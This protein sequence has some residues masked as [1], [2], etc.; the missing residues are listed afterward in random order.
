M[1]A[2]RVNPDIYTALFNAMASA[3][4]DTI[5]ESVSAL[6]TDS[7]NLIAFF[8][9]YYATNKL[10]ANMYVVKT[11][12]EKLR[13]ASLLAKK[14]IATNPVFLA[15]MLDVAGLLVSGSYKSCGCGTV[16]VEP[17]DVSAVEAI[18][19][20]FGKKR[21]EELVF[22]QEEGKVTNDLYKILNIIYYKTR[23]QDKK[24]VLGLVAF[25]TSFKT[26]ALD[27]LAY[28]ENQMVKMGK[29]D[30]IWYF[31]K[32]ALLV[33]KHRINVEAVEGFVRVHL[34]LFTLGFQKKYKGP[35][36]SLIVW[37]FSILAS[38]HVLKHV[39]SHPAEFVELYTAGPDVDF[40]DDGNV[41]STAKSAPV[42]CD[43]LKFYTCINSD[44]KKQGSL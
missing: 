22:L 1:V 14:N 12:H 26:L 36:L 34:Q 24:S 4:A 42:D 31:W 43:Y 41:E 38:K 37:V 39:C 40:L 19:A 44:L 35:R 16:V 5:V 10:T 15:L 2:K 23:Y 25:I 28:E 8:I 17:F 3:D 18:V 6:V 27:E 33:V 11:L 7:N 29:N 21:H 13:A 9:E 32:L 30:I 20:N